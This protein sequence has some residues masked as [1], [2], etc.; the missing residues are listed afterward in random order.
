VI[1]P[2][3]SL[4]FLDVHSEVRSPLDRVRVLS[5]NHAQ[6]SRREVGTPM[7]AK[8]DV[9]S[10]SLASR[11]MNTNGRAPRPSRSSFRHVGEEEAR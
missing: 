8:V 6:V 2:F 5:V 11:F 4:G 9:A 1:R 10:S 3:G 7:L